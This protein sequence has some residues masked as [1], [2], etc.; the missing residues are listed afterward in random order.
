MAKVMDGTINKRL[1][2]FTDTFP[3]GTAETFLA[4]ELPFVAAKFSEVIIHPLY[5][6][7]SKKAARTVPVN[8]RV[9]EPLLS[10]DHKNKVGL[11]VHGIFSCAP[12]MFGIR[13][14]FKRRGVRSG[15][16]SVK[17]G[18][19]LQE[20][21]GLGRRIWL[22]F[23]YFLMLRSILSNRKV[24]QTVV[25]EASM[26]DLLYFYWG[27]KSVM[28]APFIK[29]KLKKMKLQHM[30]VFLS[31]FHGSDLYE[32]AKGYLPFREN[33]YGSIDYAAPISIDGLRYI[34]KNYK[35]QPA[36]MCTWH[37]GSFHHDRDYKNSQTEASEKNKCS[38]NKIFNIV[39]CSNVIELKRVSMIA[40]ALT[41]IASDDVIV[42]QLKNKGIAG[43]HWTHFG[44][45]NMMLK[46]KLK[47]NQ[48]TAIQGNYFKKTA[49]QAS[50]K[51]DATASATA[52]AAIPYITV[53]IAGRTPHN[54]IMDYYR[55]QGADLY[56][57]VSRTEGVP[58]SIMEALSYGIPAYA[59]N[60][61]AVSELFRDCPIGKLMDKNIT[62]EILEEEIITFMQIPENLRVEMGKNAR[63]DWEENWDCNKN[64]TEFADALDVLTE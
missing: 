58:V 7:R 28:A 40:D 19:D 50:A 53:K 46:L 22:F 10:F 41:L 9:A 38:A 1:I 39:S 55:T 60:V 25:R 52:S 2:L 23:S 54:R 3:Y 42:Q 48:L 56:L 49:Q 6:P 43:I 14:F 32:S 8:V 51:T 37:L 18:N 34:Q 15:Q 20:R 57:L 31:R 36:E 44:D 35:N 17:P 61:G 64:Y 11:L 24:M 4:E 5:V 45:G 12:I 27:D 21:A 59:T 16:I 63:A 13:E 47:V 26:A 33:I 62:P 30:P 29:R